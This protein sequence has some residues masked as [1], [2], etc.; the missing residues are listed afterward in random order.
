MVITV[1]RVENPIVT[2]SLILIH[3]T[4]VHT[5]KS[6]QV[7]NVYWCFKAENNWVA[8]LFC[9]NACYRLKLKPRPIKRFNLETT[10]FT[11]CLPYYFD[12][13]PRKYSNENGL[14]LNKCY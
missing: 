14:K 7:E 13:K 2:F 11:E 6:G 3:P 8:V 9:N 12:S 5:V 1:V 4:A 10:V